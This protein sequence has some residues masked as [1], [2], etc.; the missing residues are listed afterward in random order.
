MPFTD[1]NFYKDHFGV[2]GKFVILTFGL[3]GRSKG[4]EN[5]IKA[6]PEILKHCPNAVY[7]VVG[8]THPHVVKSEGE[9]YRISCS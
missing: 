8:A 2:E 6:L 7:M 1:P 4:I 3:L 9:S 5:V